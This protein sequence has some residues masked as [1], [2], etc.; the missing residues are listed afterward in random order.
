MVIF[1]LRQKKINLQNNL[2]GKGMVR[3]EEGGGRMGLRVTE[4]RK[5]TEK[6]PWEE[7]ESRIILTDE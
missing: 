1:V 4:R 5:L 7:K 6:T 2:E 3:G